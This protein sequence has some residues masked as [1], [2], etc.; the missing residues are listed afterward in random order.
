M[1]FHYK[2]LIL[3]AFILSLFCA[4]MPDRADTSSDARMPSSPA[5]ADEPSAPPEAPGRNQSFLAHM[6]EPEYDA[7]FGTSGMRPSDA[8]LSPDGTRLLYFYPAEFEEE[9]GLYC[10]ELQTKSAQTLLRQQDIGQTQSIKQAQW[11][12]EQSLLLIIGYRYGTV[13]PGGSVYLLNLQEAP[14]LR[15][16]YATRT[17]REQVLSAS[18]SGDALAMKVAVYDDAFNE[19]TEQAR[20]ITVNPASA[21]VAQLFG[22][23]NAPEG[24]LAVLLNNPQEAQLAAYPNIDVYEYDQS[25]ECLLLVPSHEGTRVTLEAMT[26]DQTKEVFVPNGVLYDKMSMAGQAL[27][28]KAV[29]AEGGPRLRLTL[30]YQERTVQYDVVYNAKDGT[31]DREVLS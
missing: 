2:I 14:A 3:A 20:T 16:L 5:S 17:E 13:S 31:P 24:A 15:L 29:R 11:Q 6:T 28:L 18:L 27:S 10:Y 19:Y 26:F 7:L 21:P 25:G 12:D 23:P 9:A 1:R 22:E 30:T 8:T 4:C